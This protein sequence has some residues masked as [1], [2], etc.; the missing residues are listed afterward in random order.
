MS[1]CYMVGLLKAT[2]RAIG[3]DVAG[4]VSA[5][6]WNTETAKFAGE[7]HSILMYSQC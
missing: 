3:A 4:V 7:L 5:P 6:L 1:C 2:V